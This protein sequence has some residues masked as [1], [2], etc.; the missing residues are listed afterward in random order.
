[1]T[2]PIIT[3]DALTKHLR[4]GTRALDGLTL[5]IPTG[6][7]YYSGSMP[8][9]PSRQR[10]T[11]GRHPRRG[12]ARRAGDSADGGEQGPYTPAV[13]APGSTT[14][15]ARPVNASVGG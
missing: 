9:R 8:R 1:V 10:A 11:A 2:D 7:V 13:L 4:D 15:L 6:T 5:A 12:R 3:V 14:A